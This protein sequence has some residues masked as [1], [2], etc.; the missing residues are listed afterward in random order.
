M[1]HRFCASTLASLGLTACS[2]LA[3]TLVA[4]PL[5]L[6]QTK[7]LGQLET[8][9]W[10]Q[11][12]FQNWSMAATTAQQITALK[13]LTAA[14]RS[15]YTDLHYYLGLLQLNVSLEE[16]EVLR[17]PQ[18]V[19]RGV[20]VMVPAIGSTL[21]DGT[22][23]GPMLGHSIPSDSMLSSPVSSDAIL[24]NPILSSPILSSPILSSPA[25]ARPEVGGS[26]SDRRPLD[27][28]EAVEKHKNQM[29]REVQ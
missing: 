22:L 8:R 17:S 21:P 1:N 20:R 24:S 15:Y 19:A 3:A 13:T 26:G 5:V 6:A 7:T 10:D 29:M 25:L 16:P 14:Q 11:I 4:S 23:G 27:W 28:D 9:L 2:W 12:C 18:C